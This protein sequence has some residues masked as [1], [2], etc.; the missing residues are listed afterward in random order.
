MIINSII[1]SRMNNIFFYLANG[2]LPSYLLFTFKPFAWIFERYIYYSKQDIKFWCIINNDKQV[3]I[4]SL[5][6][7]SL[8][9]RQTRR[10][11]DQD[12]CLIL[13][14]CDVLLR[15]LCS[16][17]CCM[18]QQELRSKQR[19]SRPHF[20]YNSIAHPN[21]SLS[22]F[23]T[24][25]RVLL[26]STCEGVKKKNTPNCKRNHPIIRIKKKKKS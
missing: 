22:F 11:D 6:L 18:Q 7:L 25:S 10:D 1:F 17:T 24:F 4:F 23:I 16:P 2:I 26:F 13:C 12:L 19:Q 5:F 8:E 21:L 15:V 9:D 20:S 14:V 3:Y